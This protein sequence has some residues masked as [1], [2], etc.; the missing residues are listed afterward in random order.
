MELS[1]ERGKTA[2]FIDPCQREHHGREV[3]STLRH[4]WHKV[5]YKAANNISVV[6]VQMHW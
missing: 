1:E 4:L 2:E 5:Q 3:R 6:V